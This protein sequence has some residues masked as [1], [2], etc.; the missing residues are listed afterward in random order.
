MVRWSSQYDE[1]EWAAGNVLDGKIGQG[2][3]WSSKGLERTPLYPQELIVQLDSPSSIG[4]VE[5]N[6]FSVEGQPNWVKDVS[7]LTGDSPDGP[8][9]L[10]GRYTL[11]QENRFQPLTFGAKA[12]R[13]VMIRVE[14]NWGGPFAQMGEVS[15]YGLEGGAQTTPSPQGGQKSM[16]ERPSGSSSLPPPAVIPR[17]ASPA[18]AMPPVSSQGHKVARWTS[19]FNGNSWAAR[20]LTDGQ[21]GPDHEW[22]SAPNSPP[23]P[24]EIVI[25][26]AKP[27]KISK[28]EINPS[29]SDVNK[30]R[31]T[32]Q[33]GLYYG[34]TPDGPWNGV[35]RR[36]LEQKNEF[37][38]FEFLFPFEASYV[39]VRVESNW[40]GNYTHMSEIRISGEAVSGQ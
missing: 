35:A 22:S 1:R 15:I 11:S 2:S 40:G 20:N 32:K 24:Q 23:V 21:T 34:N 9:N 36:E 5:I 39:L 28:I 27:A 7:I 4:R 37:Q 25:Q 17:T 13:F 10:A 6:P 18:T 12:G 26:L 16:A 19:Q 8:W 33:V 14:S 38:S 29:S 31:W 30:T 3:G